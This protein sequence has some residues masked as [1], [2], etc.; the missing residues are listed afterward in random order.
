MQELLNKISKYNLWDSK[1]FDSGFIRTHYLNNIKKYIGNKLIKVLV[2]QRRVG[3]SYLLRQIMASLVKDYNVNPKNIFYLNK[4]YLVYNSVLNA[5]DLQE[6]IDFYKTELKVEGKIYIFIDEIQNIDKWESFVNSYSQDFT[7]EYEIFISGSNS[8]MLSGE[9]SSLLSGRYIE[10]RIMPFDLVEYASFKN[11][12][13]NRETFIAYINTSGLPEL[14]NIEN[15]DAKVNYVSALRNTIILRDILYRF[16]IKDVV[17]LD[18]LFAFISLNIGNLTSVSSIIKYYKSKNKKTNF[19]TI[20]NYLGYLRDTFIISEVGKY[21]IKGKQLL[22]GEK[23]Y[24][25]TDLGF[26]NYLFGITPNDIGNMLENFVFNVLLQKNYFIKV[27]VWNA[28]E[29]D[30]VATKNNRTIYIQVAYLL[31]EQ[32]TIDRE[33]GNLLNINDNHEKIVVSLDQVQF[34][35]Y[36]GIK[37][38]FPWQLEGVLK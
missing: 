32:K 30:F 21:N 8:K 13:I 12:E 36:K 20:S 38:M 29:I 15:E 7:Q 4:E 16:N 19:D 5:N 3:K 31:N 34:T 25:L 33:F 27:G 22:G 11:I 10:F 9:L 2:G 28:N 14:F 18:E 24:Y 35:N 1:T 17:L 6:I 23:K 37:H 26:K